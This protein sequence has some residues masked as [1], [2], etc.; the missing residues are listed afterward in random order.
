[1][2]ELLHAEP[3]ACLAWAIVI[4]AVVAATWSGIHANAK[5]L[6]ERE[7]DW[8]SAIKWANRMLDPDSD[9]ETDDDERKARRRLQARRILRGETYYTC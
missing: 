8:V 2:Y 7:A 6:K 1:M 3:L 4:T 9:Q 5:A